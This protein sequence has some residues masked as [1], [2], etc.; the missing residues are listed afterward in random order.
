MR[1]TY[2]IMP[3]ALGITKR[4]RTQRAAKLPPAVARAIVL[5]LLSKASIVQR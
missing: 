5:P 3:Q 4:M 2:G 1:S